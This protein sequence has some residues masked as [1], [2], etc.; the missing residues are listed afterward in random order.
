VHPFFRFPTF[1][2]LVAAVSGCAGFGPV[3]LRNERTAYNEAIHDTNSEQLLLNI[4]R[5]SQIE[6]QSFSTLAEVDSSPTQSLL[7][8][9][10]SSNIVAPTVLGGLNSTVGA[11]ETSIQ[12]HVTISGF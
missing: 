3:I 8:V 9:G 7:V 11:S 1:A 10:G 6:A 4:V 5:S 12:K 2:V